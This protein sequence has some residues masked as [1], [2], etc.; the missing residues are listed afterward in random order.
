[1]PETR[2]TPVVQ[3]YDDDDDLEFGISIPASQTTPERQ[4]NEISS[5][6]LLVELSI[7]IA[8]SVAVLGHFYATGNP[9][10]MITAVPAAFALDAVKAG[11]RVTGRLVGGAFN[12]TRSALTGGL[13]LANDARMSIDQTVRDTA[14]EAVTSIKDGWQRRRQAAMDRL[15]E[16]ILQKT[17]H[18]VPP[19]DN[20][21]SQLEEKI[22]HYQDMTDTQ[23]EAYRQQLFKNLDLQE[24][25]LDLQAQQEA[26]LEEANLQIDVLLQ[27]ALD[28]GATE[29]DLEMELRQERLRRAP[30]IQLS[31][32]LLMVKRRSD[33]G[34]N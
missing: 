22:Q 32:R 4:R 12:T 17:R 26:D 15:N 5:K 31:T 30:K 2:N 27:A 34:I 23:R 11:G 33:R 8:T 14:S 28:R 9:D 18:L 10:A 29:D 24:Q 7:R 1:M 6:Q 13:D 3:D 16:A 25:L 20:R 19:V 21:L